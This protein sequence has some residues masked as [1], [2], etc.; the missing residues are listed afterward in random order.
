[1]I[2]QHKYTKMTGLPFYKSS[3]NN[4]T[5][6]NMLTTLNVKHFH[7]LEKM[8]KMFDIMLS[9]SELSLNKASITNIHAP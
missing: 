8:K 4:S 6:K 7:L 2:D 1:M 9:K 3:K 5:L